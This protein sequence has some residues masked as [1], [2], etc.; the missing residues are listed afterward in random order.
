MALT[1]TKNMW[2]GKTEYISVPKPQTVASNSSKII[3]SSSTA[4]KRNR[5]A[6]TQTSQE[7][8]KLMSMASVEVPNSGGAAFFSLEGQKQAVGRVL[9]VLNPF[10]NKPISVVN[11][12]TRTVVAEDVGAFVRSTVRIS[13]AA[14]VVPSVLP[15]TTAAGATVAAV[16]SS[17]SNTAKLPIIF[18]ALGVGA[19]ALLFNKPETAPQNMTTITYQ[20]TVTNQTTNT[21][22]D[23]YNNQYIINSPYAAPQLFG[24]PS[25]SVIPAQ[26]VT[27]SVDVTPSQS[28]QAG[29]TD[30]TTIILVAA[31]A[32]LLSR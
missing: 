15:A 28:Q 27:P 11:P 21:S 25:Q 20:T 32:Y 6:I 3:P 2:T 5:T 30:L 29:G 18:G 7:T 13:E 16:G 22:Q 26:S 12:F 31:A 1:G 24:N 9:D 19:G 10:S 14:L 17:V 8:P 4:S 23:T